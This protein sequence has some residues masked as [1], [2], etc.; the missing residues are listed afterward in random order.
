MQPIGL[1]VRRPS[2]DHAKPLRSIACVGIPQEGIHDIPQFLREAGLHQVCVFEVPGLSVRNDRVAKD[3]VY[4][5]RVSSLRCPSTDSPRE[6]P[7]VLA[8][9]LRIVSRPRIRVCNCFTSSPMSR[10]LQKSNQ[11]AHSQD[12]WT[13]RQLTSPCSCVVS[14]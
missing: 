5:S 13:T 11:Q 6:P 3:T 2:H 1:W 7:V 12:L 9:I 10:S 4:M 8:S 14:F